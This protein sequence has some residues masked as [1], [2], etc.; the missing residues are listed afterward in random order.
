[1]CDNQRGVN[2]RT[3]Q[4]FSRVRRVFEG[5]LRALLPPSHRDAKILLQHFAHQRG[6][7]G[8]TRPTAADQDRQAETPP[9]SRRLGEALEGKRPDSVGHAGDIAALGIGG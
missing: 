1:V 3:A 4:D 8:A 2:A 5:V 6:E 7:G 9:L